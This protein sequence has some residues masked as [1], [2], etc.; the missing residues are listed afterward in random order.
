[1]VYL[2][3]YY[4][5]VNGALIFVDLKQFMIARKEVIKYTKKYIQDIEERSAVR[6]PCLLVGAKVGTLI[7]HIME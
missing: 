2:Q 4:R 1:M 3:S 6:H 5:G 7:M